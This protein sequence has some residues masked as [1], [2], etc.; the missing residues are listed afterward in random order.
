MAIA[1]AAHLIAAPPTVTTWTPCAAETAS[2]SFTGTH[3]VAFGAAGQFF[4]GSFTG[5]TPCGNAVFGDPLSGVAKA[6]YV[7]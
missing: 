5:G 7:Q 4:S 2:C 6:C 1:V 3:E